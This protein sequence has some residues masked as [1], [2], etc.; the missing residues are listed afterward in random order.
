MSEP[1]PG[2]ADALVRWVRAGIRSMAADGQELRVRGLDRVDID[3][4]VD[5]VDVRRLAIDATGAKVAFQVNVDDAAPDAVAAEIAPIAEEPGILRDFRLRAQ[6]MHVEGRE[7][8]IDLQ[9]HDV[10]IAW[11]TYPCPV[12]RSMPESVHML[13]PQSGAGGRG[14][15]DASMRTQDIGPLITAVLRPVLAEGGIR[16]GRVSIDVARLGPDRIH[17]RGSA[18][19]RWKVVPVSA[20]AELVVTTAPDGV[21]TIDDLSVGSG[22]PIVKIAL[23][24]ARGHIA[25]ARG[26]SI[27]LTAMLADNGSTGRIHD[28]SITT[29]ERF[30]I[31][32]RLS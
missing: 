2:D 23:L 20:R 3:A 15:L 16:L 30:G 24:F 9:A 32:G 26:T 21:I 17:V 29:G 10:P 13:E 22:N 1:W 11:N 19:A 28:L 6:P 27:D 18:R 14:S 8:R 25:S 4:E 31:S 7:L 12:H 5:G